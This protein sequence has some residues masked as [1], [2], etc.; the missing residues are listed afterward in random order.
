MAKRYHYPSTLASFTDKDDTIVSK[1]SQKITRER[2]FTEQLLRDGKI[3]LFL[4]GFNEVLEHLVESTRRKIQSFIDTYPNSKI[5]IASRPVAYEEIEFKVS[6]N[7]LLEQRKPIPAFLLLE[8]KEELIENFVKNNYS[9]DWKALFRFLK[10]K[11]NESLFNMLKTP[12]YLAEFIKTYEPDRQIPATT[13]ILTGKFLNLKYEREKEKNAEF[14]KNIFHSA[15]V[16]YTIEI[17]VHDDFGM[18]NPQVPKLVAEKILSKVLEKS[19]LT[20]AEFLRYA[21]SLNILLYHRIDN[22][23]SFAHQSYQDF[24]MDEES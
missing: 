5:I 8:M 6:D 18:Q 4:D 21:V 9:G 24:Y 19:K 20:I 10:E 15:L 2:N 14:D 23:Y 3:I 1:I 11:K 22:S 7:S 17:S 13:T 12:L 16:A